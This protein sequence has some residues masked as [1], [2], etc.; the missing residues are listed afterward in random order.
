[1]V[2]IK[3]SVLAG[4]YVAIFMA[5]FPLHCNNVFLVRLELSSSKTVVLT[6]RFDN[7]IIVSHYCENWVDYFEYSMQ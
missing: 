2:C 3:T 4:T 5:T 7:N 6:Y 1:M